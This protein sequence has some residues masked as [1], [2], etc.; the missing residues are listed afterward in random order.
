M[1]LKA[2]DTPT[3]CDPVVRALVLVASI[4]ESF[5]AATVTSPVAP[6]VLFV[7][8]VLFVTYPSALL[9]TVLV[10]ITAFTASD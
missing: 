6:P 8:T 1:V 10:A 5:V 2:K 3:A 7:V 9:S 4:D